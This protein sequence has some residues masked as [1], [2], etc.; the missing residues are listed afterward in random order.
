MI[1]V[2]PLP[3]T[4]IA[5][6]AKASTG[7]AHCKPSSAHGQCCWI[8]SKC[9]PGEREVVLRT[10]I[11]M[12]RDATPATSYSGNTLSENLIWLVAILRD[13]AFLTYHTPG[14]TDTEVQMRAYRCPSRT[15]NFWCAVRLALFLSCMSD[16][17]DLDEEQEKE[18][19]L[20][21]DTEIPYQRPATPAEMWPQ[22]A[23]V[24]AS[25]RDRGIYT[26]LQ[27]CR[28]D[29]VDVYDV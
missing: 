24:Q 5:H 12:L 19:L 18:E 3:L 17:L 14:S 29:S 15:S 26:V 2:V 21:T 8:P 11:R 13:G 27:A 28:G 10:L 6:H 4:S 9:R 25:R 23:G 16:V 7:R 20:E 1:L 22:G